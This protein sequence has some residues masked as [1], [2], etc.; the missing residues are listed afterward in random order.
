MKLL[1]LNFRQTT[2]VYINDVQKVHCIGN[3]PQ[4]LRIYVP[5]RKDQPLC[6][7]CLQY[8]VPNWNF[9]LINIEDI[10]CEKIKIVLEI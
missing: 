6:V 1:K 10:K 5:T 9:K 2:N 7:R 4:C 3:S 8:Y